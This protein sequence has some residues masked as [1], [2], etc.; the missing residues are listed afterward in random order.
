M[1]LGG[2]IGVMNSLT[3]IGGRKGIGKDFIKDLNWK[4]TKP[5]YSLYALANYRDAIAL[6]LE[7][8]FGQLQSYDSLLKKT[9]PSL[10]GRYGRNLSF[11]TPINEIQLALEI[12]PFFFKRYDEGEAPYLSPYVIAGI[13]YFSYNPQAFIKGQWH[14]LHPLHLE[15]QG[16]SE[17][18]DRKPYSLHQLNI[19]V[20]AGL[21]YEVTPSLN[22]RLEIVHRILTT[23]Y[24][25]DVSDNYIDPV[26]FQQY[27]LPAQ[28]V[29]ATQLYSRMEE[30]QPGYKVTTTMPRGDKK[31][32][33]AF[34][35]IQLKAGFAIR[36]A[37]R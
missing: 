12:H 3:D 16:F 29:I 1:E 13:G 20:G 18:P 14:A 25:D 26:L 6:R 10:T 5:S 17:Y 2:S 35:S 31:D 28:A 23:D 34:F 24:L 37:K 22:L 21:R 27:L 32:N 36:T 8:T 11:K 15:G 4:V 33:D 9:D 7:A 19:P 30:L